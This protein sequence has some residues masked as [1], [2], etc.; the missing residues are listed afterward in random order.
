MKQL[1]ILI[2]LLF[3]CTASQSDEPQASK[4]DAGR[5]LATASTLLDNI[6]TEAAVRNLLPAS[7]TVSLTEP[8]P[9]SG[10]IK[11]DGTFESVG[12]HS[13]FDVAADFLACAVDSEQLD[14]SVRWT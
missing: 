6:D 14:G 5:A 9:T 7:G 8:C 1:T 10:S 11:L 13:E 4:R 3:A 12:T 2:P